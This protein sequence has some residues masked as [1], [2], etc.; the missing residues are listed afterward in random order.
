MCFLVAAAMYTLHLPTS[1]YQ[2]LK[3]LCSQSTSFIMSPIS[4]QQL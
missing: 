1:C 4:L 2:S 3:K